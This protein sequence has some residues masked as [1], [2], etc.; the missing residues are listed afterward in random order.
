[1][2]KNSPLYCLTVEAEVKE[3]LRLGR[4]A[5]IIIRELTPRGEASISWKSFEKLLKE[6]G[7][8]QGLKVDLDKGELIPQS[9]LDWEWI[10]E[11]YQNS[12][13]N[14]IALEVNTQEARHARS[15]FKGI[16]S[17]GSIP[18]RE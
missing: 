16:F 17:D 18:V 12:E 14:K 15:V 13:K 1:M 11:V 10:E 6:L 8:P 4:S 9:P 5:S 2:R 7:A 3:N